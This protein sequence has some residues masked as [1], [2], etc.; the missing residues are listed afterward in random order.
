MIYLTFQIAISESFDWIY[1]MK[2]EQHL[3]GSTKIKPVHHLTGSTSNL[4]MI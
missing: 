4:Y 3:T 2:P 1:K